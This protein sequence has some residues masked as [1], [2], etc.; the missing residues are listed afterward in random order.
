MAKAG[1][2]NLCPRFNL[3]YFSYFI[4]FY[5]R[6]KG[7]WL[8]SLLVFYL[9]F[10]LNFLFLQGSS[11]LSGELCQQSAFRFSVRMECLFLSTL[12]STKNSLDKFTEHCQIVLKNSTDRVRLRIVLA[13]VAGVRTSAVAVFLLDMRHSFFFLKALKATEP[14]SGGRDLRVEDS[15]ILAQR[16]TGNAAHSK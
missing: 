9:F 2:R 1:G 15:H 8:E 14:F 5:F 6:G 16:I 7:W 12:S 4:R 10:F 3:F 11:G 13:M